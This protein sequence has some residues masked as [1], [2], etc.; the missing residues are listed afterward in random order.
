M[1]GD[2]GIIMMIAAVEGTGEMIAEEEGGGAMI[3]EATTAVV[4][5]GMVR[6]VVA[7]QG[8]ALR[9]EISTGAIMDH[10][11]L[12]VPEGEACQRRMIAATPYPVGATPARDQDLGVIL[13]HR[14]L[15]HVLLGPGVTRRDLRGAGATLDHARAVTLGRHRGIRS[16]RE[17]EVMAVVAAR[18]DD[19]VP[20]PLPPQ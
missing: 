18:E 1:D 7:G 19:P 8:V 5:V 6:L 13:L 15:G 2:L 14:D 4:E 12:E 16:E 10:H 3:E 9:I 20:L 17:V 11:R